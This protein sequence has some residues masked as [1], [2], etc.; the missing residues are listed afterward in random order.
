[1]KK[2][3]AVF[4][5]L[6]ALCSFSLPALANE[7]EH[8]AEE[9]YA[10][11]VPEENEV[12]SAPEEEYV[13]EFQEHKIFVDGKEVP[14]EPA[15]LVDGYTVLYRYTSL[16][17]ALGLAVSFDAETGLVHTD[18]NGYAITFDAIAANAS[19][20]HNGEPTDIY[21]DQF[22]YDFINMDDKLYIEDFAVKYDLAD[23]SDREIR[24]DDETNDI[25]VYT[26]EGKQAM[27]DAL[28]KNF[29]ILNSMQ[30]EVQGKDYVSEGVSEIVLN[31][32]SDFLEIEGKGQSSISVTSA[33]LGDKSYTKIHTEGK[34]LMNLI[35]L[36]TGIVNSYG[37]AAEHPADF[38]DSTD[39]ELYFDGVRLYIK[40]E[41]ATRQLLMQEA[42]WITYKFPEKIAEITKQWICT[43]SI[44]EK[45]FSLW[46]EG[47][48]GS[49]LVDLAFTS[50]N[51]TLPEE[52]IA[53][54]QALFS[55]ENF[56]VTDDAQGKTYTY[57]LN[58]EA[59]LAALEP[60]TSDMN[61]EERNAFYKQMETFGFEMTAVQNTTKDG[62]VS[63]SEAN[64]SV[65]NIENPW[66]EQMFSLY[67]SLKTS[68][69]FSFSGAESFAF[70]DVS[71]AVNLTEFVDNLSETP[72]EDME[73]EDE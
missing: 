71:Q 67:L 27:A 3:L 32:K 47:N 34:G 43:E 65:S 52:I 70:P 59:F 61:E 24:V 8:A 26:A 72:A 49:I 73:S 11:S 29:T 60:V 63:L 17:E 16:A 4:L 46:T 38:P 41:E 6:C 14:C 12:E 1:M 13:R 33:K 21:E 19:G 9:S 57:T 54:F 15:I 23:Y 42:G 20:T 40:G 69:E 50:G 39:V 48:L 45:Q 35:P 5:C 37:E 51:N 28:N 64:I 10:E 30:A 66:N 62:G 55:D 44:P 36:L 31:L 68:E 25:Y 7:T 53:V 2:L 18:G 58:K 56:T 22:I